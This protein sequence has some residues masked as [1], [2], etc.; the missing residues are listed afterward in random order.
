MSQNLCEWDLWASLDRRAGGAR[1]AELLPSYVRCSIVCSDLGPT[2]ASTGL[3][4]VG[5]SP[6]SPPL[7]H[8]RITVRR[9]KNLGVPPRCGKISRSSLDGAGLSRLRGVRIIYYRV[10]PKVRV[11]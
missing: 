4:S 7:S 9:P 5:H 2:D 10:V 3:L 11:R 8:P 1:A 6:K